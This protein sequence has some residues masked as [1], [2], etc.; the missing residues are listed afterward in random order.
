MERRLDAAAL[1]HAEI[2]AFADHL[3]AQILAGDANRIV[4]A[5]ADRLVGFVRGADIGADAAEEEQIDLRFEDGADELLRRDVLADAE[6]LLRLGRKPDFL[7]AAR[8]DAAAFGDQRLV[9][10]LPARTR[11]IEQALAFG[12]GPLRI[13]V[14]IDENIAVI[15][16]GDELGRLLAQ[17]AVAE[18]VARHVADADH[19][20][21]RQ[22][23]Y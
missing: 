6:Q 11:Q 21:R 9:E 16:C 10:I 5:V 18:H 3:A 22:S 13:G 8:I 1:R 20:E 12:E 23:G 14:G 2:G 19:G 4:G 17:H 7:G 15:E